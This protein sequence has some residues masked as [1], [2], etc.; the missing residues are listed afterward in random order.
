[1]P[2]V[3]QFA[4]RQEAGKRLAKVVAASVDPKAAVVLAL[5]RGGCRLV[6]RSRRPWRFL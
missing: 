6:T 2:Q 4:D 5:P 3:K 1:M